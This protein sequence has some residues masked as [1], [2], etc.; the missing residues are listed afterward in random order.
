MI[1]SDGSVVLEFFNLSL[2]RLFLLLTVDC[3]STVGV[4]VSNSGPA[5]V[6]EVVGAGRACTTGGGAL[7]LDKHIGLFLKILVVQ[8]FQL[9]H[10]RLLALQVT[11]VF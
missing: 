4:P 5:D 8:L 3:V 2:P 10:Y 9:S 1:E 6:D 7:G 11:E